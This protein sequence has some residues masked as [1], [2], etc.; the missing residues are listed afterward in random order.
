MIRLTDTPEAVGLASTLPRIK[1]EL[2][3]RVLS[4]D[5]AFENDR[6]TDVIFDSLQEMLNECKGDFSNDDDK[7]D[8]IEKCIQPKIHSSGYKIFHMIPNANYELLRLPGNMRFP[9]VVSA[10]ILR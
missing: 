4:I 10:Y 3:L 5:S 7:I 1:V 6:P 8:A 2:V 9:I